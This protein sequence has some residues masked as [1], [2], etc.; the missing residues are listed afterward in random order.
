MFRTRAILGLNKSYSRKIRKA[1][2]ETNNISR[3][4]P[5]SQHPFNRICNEHIKYGDMEFKELEYRW[6][7]TNYPEDLFTRDPALKS[8][9]RFRSDETDEPII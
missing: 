3:T 1:H 2:P 4:I 7:E 8:V 6:W 9:Y 5:S